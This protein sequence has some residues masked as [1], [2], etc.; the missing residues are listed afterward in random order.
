LAN[1]VVAFPHLQRFGKNASVLANPVVA[2]PH[3]QRFGKN[4]SVLANPVVAL[5]DYF[6][7]SKFLHFII[8]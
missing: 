1:P 7:P 8:S 2:F 4:A 3:L 6:F 5:L